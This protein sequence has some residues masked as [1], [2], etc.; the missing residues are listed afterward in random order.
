MIVSVVNQSPVHGL[1]LADSR[2]CPSWPAN[3]ASLYPTASDSLC[4]RRIRSYFAAQPG[5]L[6]YQTIQTMRGPVNVTPLIEQARLLEEHGAF[7]G[8]ARLSGDSRPSDGRDIL[9]PKATS[10]QSHVNMA[11]PNLWT[12]IHW[13]RIGEN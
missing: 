1:L 5:A 4:V 9:A 12:E 8:P 2:R 6:P 10:G 11:Y 7:I 13:P 3:S